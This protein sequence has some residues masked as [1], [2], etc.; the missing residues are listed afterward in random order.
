MHRSGTRF[1]LG[2][3]GRAEEKY[4]REEEEEEID[5]YPQLGCNAEQAVHLIPFIL[6]ACLLVL[7]I[8][9]Y[10]PDE[11]S[12]P[13]TVPEKDSV[14]EVKAASIPV[15]KKEE[16]LQTFSVYS[17]RSLQQVEKHQQKMK[18]GIPKQQKETNR[19][20]MKGNRHDIRRARPK[21]NSFHR[22]TRI[23]HNN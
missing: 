15:G 4:E 1:K 3:R 21:K 18:K 7:Y 16:V 17:H 19:R 2:L 14:K 5:K 13:G 6:L 11:G 22:K 23:I 10:T 12:I 9:S 8:F 20:L